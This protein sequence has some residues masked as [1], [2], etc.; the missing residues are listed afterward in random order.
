MEKDKIPKLLA[1][2]YK[3]N[4]VICNTT[5]KRIIIVSTAETERLDY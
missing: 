3:I 2:A 4:S 1:T 5:I